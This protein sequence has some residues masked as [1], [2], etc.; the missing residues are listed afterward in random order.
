MA[1]LKNPQMQIPGGYTF[2]EPATKWQPPPFSSLDSITSQLIA[3]RKGRPDLIQKYGWHLDPAVVL[4]EVM[5]YNIALC[6]SR[7]WTD[8]LVGEA[9]ARPFHPAP[10]RNI[11]QKVQAVAGGAETLIDWIKSGDEAVPVAL[12]NKRSEICVKCPMNKPG[13]FEAFFTV[14]IAN[15]IH[16]AMQKRLDLKLTTEND[17]KLHV[18]EACLCPLPLKIWMPLERI[19]AKMKPSVQAALH[20]D[21]WILKHDA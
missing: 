7:G 11:L 6:Q 13:G 18:C 21:C 14:P 9:D 4:Q 19:L 15:A 5:N 17:D 20:S 16:A 1:T 2:L 8:Y 3:H 12:A 10:R